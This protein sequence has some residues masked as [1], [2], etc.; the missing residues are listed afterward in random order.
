MATSPATIEHILSVLDDVEVFSTRAMFGEY[1]LYAYGRTVALV[2]NDQLYVKI[3][4]QSAA[5][6][7]VC[8]Q[9][10]PYPGAKLHYLVEESQL[11]ILDGL[12]DILCAIAHALPPP[13]KKKGKKRG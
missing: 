7:D 2:C 5:L 12:P 13:K 9:D 1:A 10:T 6:L 11:P 4:P 3:L 8:E